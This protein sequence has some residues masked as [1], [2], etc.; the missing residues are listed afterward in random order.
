MRFPRWWVKASDRGEASGSA[1][2]VE[3]WG[4]GDSEGA[5]RAEASTRLR[6]I[7]DRIAAGERLPSGYG[8][9]TR[10][11]R[12]A[13]LDVLS[14]PDD[15]PDAVITRNQYGALVL[16]TTRLAFVDVDVP[17]PTLGDTLGR[18]FGRPVAS[19]A[20][21]ERIRQAL[22]QSGWGGTFR[23]YRTAG[24]YRILATD[25]EFRPASS[26]TAALMTAVGADPAYVNLCRVQQSFRARLS[27]KPWRCGLNSP[28][29]GLLPGDI[30]NH[31]ACEQWLAEYDA[32]GN[33]HAT[34]QYLETVGAGQP[35]AWAAP[36]IAIHDAR[37]RAD[38]TLPLA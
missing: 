32:A 2:P 14:G 33:R 5:A 37:T 10:P 21:R 30:D 23:L 20:I 15:A 4:W 26:D 22:K 28:P 3:A 31:Q 35:A 9:G 8:Y 17:E 34:C 16:N 36:L 7:L 19:E 1:H 27:P 6:R 11:V 25:R 18:L 12:E 24:G 38:T 29:T 13:V